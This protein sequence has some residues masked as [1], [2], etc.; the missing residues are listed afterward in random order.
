M[1]PAEQSR[2]WCFGQGLLV[3]E[4]LL[5]ALAGM[6]GLLL[7]GWPAE[8]GLACLLLGMVARTLGNV[9]KRPI[10]GRAVMAMARASVPTRIRPPP[11]TD[12]AKA[13][14]LRDPDAMRAPMAKPNYSFEKRQRELA[15]KKK[16]DE[17]QAKKRAG[18]EAARPNP[19]PQE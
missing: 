2:G 17:K 3:A 13:R 6:V 9:L 14:T 12:R 7:I 15:K 11:G 8:A 4:L 19:P 10:A 16:Q 5:V 1:A 18:R